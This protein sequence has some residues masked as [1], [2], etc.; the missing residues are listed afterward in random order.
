MSNVEPL[1]SFEPIG[2]A[3]KRIFVKIGSAKVTPWNGGRIGKPGIYSGVSMD[4]YHGDLCIG[5]SISSSGLRT[6]EAKS[7]L[8]YYATSYLNPGRVGQTA[9]D[10]F[11]FGRAA[12]TL[13]LGETGFRDQF[14]I[15]PAEFKD[16]KTKAAQEWRNCVRDAGKTPLATDDL[17]AIKAIAANLDAHPLARDLLRGQ[18]EQS[19]VFRDEVTGVW[20][21]SRP[22]V[23]PAD[24]IVA[25]LKTTTDASPEAVRKSILNFGYAMQA[26]VVGEAMKS[27]LGT[28]MTTFALVFVEKAAP[29]AVSIVE[30]DLDWIAYASRQVRRSIDIF[31]K[32]IETNEW[33]GYEGEPVVYMPDWLRKRLDEQT[34][35]GLLPR[36]YAA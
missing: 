10:A 12:H 16:Y 27:V 7:P 8:H 15:R 30:V 33:P 13:L 19:L 23:L 1:N 17:T 6:I 31:A 2:E 4:A 22:D 26:A 25:D 28:D 34:D 24:G 20:I 36:E 21:K 35:V 3:A 14:V 32:C 9:N 29:Y 11:D 5:P 18:V